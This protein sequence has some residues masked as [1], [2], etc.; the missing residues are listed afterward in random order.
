MVYSTP[1]SNGGLILIA[2]KVDIVKVNIISLVPSGGNDKE[3]IYLIQNYTNLQFAKLT[4][5]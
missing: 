4:P 1:E 2:H 3:T 5:L